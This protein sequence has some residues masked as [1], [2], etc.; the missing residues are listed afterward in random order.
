[1]WQMKPH[2]EDEQNTVSHTQWQHKTRGKG[3][4]QRGKACIGAHENLRSTQCTQFLCHTH[5]SPPDTHHHTKV[6]SNIIDMSND[7]SCV[8][9]IE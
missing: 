2:N 8:R 7:P 1:M 5:Y 6:M 4:S 9:G 3:T